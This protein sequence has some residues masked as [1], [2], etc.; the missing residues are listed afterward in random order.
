MW[1]F[2]LLLVAVVLF[3]N[4]EPIE[5]PSQTSTQVQGVKRDKTDPLADA[6]QA[7]GQA[8]LQLLDAKIGKKVQDA[9]KEVTDFLTTAI[10]SHSNARADSIRQDKQKEMSLLH[11]GTMHTIQKHVKKT[12]DKPQLQKKKDGSFLVHFKIPYIVTPLDKK[13]KKQSHHSPKHHAHHIHHIK[14]KTTQ[15]KPPPIEVGRKPYHPVYHHAATIAPNPYS[16]S[17]GAGYTTGYGSTHAATMAPATPAATAAGMTPCQGSCTAPCS[18]QC[19]AATDC[20]CCSD[21]NA[22]MAP[23]AMPMSM[24]PP[25]PPMLTNPNQPP[26]TAQQFSQLP[27]LPGSPIPPGACPQICKRHC[28]AKCPNECCGAGKRNK[29]EKPSKSKPVKIEKSKQ[30]TK[31]EEKTEK[32]D[33]EDDQ[34]TSQDQ[35]DEGSANEAAADEDSVE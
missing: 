4:G 12:E 13:K 34:E 26:L 7:A 17:T 3:V 25:P 30:E 8:V 18:P 23:P 16:Q 24:P 10:G 14:H 32:D 35:R 9:A 15:D 29:V 5:K 27:L 20:C 6:E 33:N 28:I 2:V 31:P 21:P 11:L 1:R 22:A 19:S